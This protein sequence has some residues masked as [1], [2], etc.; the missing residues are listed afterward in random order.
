MGPCL[1][2]HRLPIVLSL[3][4]QFCHINFI[5]ENNQHTGAS[6]KVR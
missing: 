1:C 6:S 5:N 3:K 4:S 2:A